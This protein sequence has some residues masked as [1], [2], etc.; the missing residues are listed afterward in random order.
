MISQV[1]TK[2]QGSKPRQAAQQRMHA[3]VWMEAMQKKGLQYPLDYMK[4]N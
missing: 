4:P 2:F 3:S 1:L